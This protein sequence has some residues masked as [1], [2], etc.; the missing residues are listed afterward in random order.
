MLYLHKD[1]L[2]DLF[3]FIVM[4]FVFI[5]DARNKTIS[6]CIHFSY[7]SYYLQLRLNSVINVYIRVC[8]KNY[9]DKQ[10]LDNILY[11]ATLC[12][13]I[14][15]ALFSVKSTQGHSFIGYVKLISLYYII[16]YVQLFAIQFTVLRSN[17]D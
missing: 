9:L 10:I 11:I 13:H 3:A 12:Y 15:S 7:A 14:P 4:N 6:S 8:T 17:T 2:F 16:I 1:G 5:P